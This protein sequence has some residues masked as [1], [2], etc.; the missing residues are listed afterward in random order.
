MLDRL[1]GLETEYA[2]IVRSPKDQ[3]EPPTRR[4]VYE[5]ICDQITKRLPVARGRYDADAIFLANGG[6]F[7]METSPNRLEMPGGLIEGATPEARS[8]KVLVQ[9]QRAQDRLIAEA[10][11]N[12]EIPGC[13]TIVKNSCD[14]HGHVYGC[15]ENYS[16]AVARGPMLIVYW[17]GMALVMI[18]ACLYWAACISLLAIEMAALIAVRAPWRAFRYVTGRDSA[19]QA[20]QL[21]TLTDPLPPFMLTAT[22]VALRVISMPAA[23][24]LYLV[25]RFIAFRQQR[26]HLTAFLVSRVVLTGAGYVDRANRF[27]LSGKAMAIDTVTGFGGYLGE[28]P[29]YVF[30]HWLQQLCGR[31]LLSSRSIVELFKQKQRLQI[32]LSD[33]NISDTAEYLKVATTSLVLDMIEAGYARKLPQLKRPIESLHRICSDWNLITRVETCCGEMSGLDIQRAYLRACRAYVNDFASAEGAGLN[34]RSDVR[35]A[36]AHEVL[37]RWEEVLDCLAAFRALDSQIRPSLGHVDWLTKKWMLDCLDEKP[38]ANLVP[39][40]VAPEAPIPGDSQD[41]AAKMVKRSQRWAAR[42]KVDIRYHE[43][44]DEGYFSKLKCIAPQ[45]CSVS[46]E[47]IELALRMPPT[48]SPASRRGHL[49]REFSGGLEFVEV[50]WSHVVIG[51]GKSRRIVNTA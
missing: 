3:G 11:K 2:T 22:A 50:D 27:R 17:L 13:V 30:H 23:A 5:A 45:L 28:R 31:S 39:D 16:A 32:G 42:K 41:D 20:D 25:A 18:P 19:E 6:A 26:Q 9:C 15:Q 51:T 7:S 43:L 33:S 14:A 4:A 48:G 8:P 35:Q 46:P 37:R 1:I 21:G 24:A 47:A 44:S 34:Q 12:C 10:A 29:I 49:I 38:E 36:E 40:P